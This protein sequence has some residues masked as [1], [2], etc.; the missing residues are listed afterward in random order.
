MISELEKIRMKLWIKACTTKILA[1]G[2]SDNA[3]EPCNFAD[4]AL[5]RFDKIFIKKDQS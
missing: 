3:A 5:N 1:N 2:D 4:N